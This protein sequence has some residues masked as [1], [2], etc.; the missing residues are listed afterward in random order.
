[1]KVNVKIEGIMN[2]A[3]PKSPHIVRAVTDEMMDFKTWDEALIGQ[4]NAFWKIHPGEI[5]AT[6][7]YK[8]EHF[9]GQT[10]FI[11]VSMTLHE[12]PQSKQVVQ[13]KCEKQPDDKYIIVARDSVA[14]TLAVIRENQTAFKELGIS[15]NEAFRVIYGTMAIEK[16]RRV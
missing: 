8:E 5:E 11:I 12:T 7:E 4:I 13:N 6:I 10:D 2:P 14:K 9:K 1:M 3:K 15:P 16:T